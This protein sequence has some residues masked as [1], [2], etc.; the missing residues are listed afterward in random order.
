M[1]FS[2]FIHRGIF[3]LNV[4]MVSVNAVSSFLLW[5]IFSFL[6]LSY[7]SVWSQAIQKSRDQCFWCRIA[8]FV[9]IGNWYKTNI[10]QVSQVEV[11][12]VP[13]SPIGIPLYDKDKLAWELEADLNGDT[14]K[15][16]LVHKDAKNIPRNHI[17][18][19]GSFFFK[20]NWI[21]PKLESNRAH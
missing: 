12:V 17:R 11:P 18:Y 14:L 19:N 9:F 4:E 15:F 2:D 16:R 13:P 7:V 3:K 8:R 6:M 5:D 10:F 20:K 1:K 21:S